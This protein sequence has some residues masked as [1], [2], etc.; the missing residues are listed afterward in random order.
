[1]R[2]FARENQFIGCSICREPG[3]CHGFHKKKFY[4]SLSELMIICLKHGKKT[5]DKRRSMKF[6]TPNLQPKI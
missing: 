4:V 1:M 2:S 3:I 5:I 6:V